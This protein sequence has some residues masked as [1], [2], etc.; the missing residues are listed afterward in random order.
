[1]VATAAGGTCR[2]NPSL[3]GRRPGS[4]G[5]AAEDR[6]LAWLEAQGLRLVE[7]N[8]R[9]RVGEIDLVMRDGATTVFVE[10]RLRSAPGFG[11]AAETVSWAKQRRLSAAARHYLQRHPDAARRPCR[12]DVLA[13][14]GERIDWIENAFDAS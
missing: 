8:F 13:I 5:T 12:F 6:G 14:T 10:V 7:R 2:R 11:S 1:V 3:T 9:C 4:A